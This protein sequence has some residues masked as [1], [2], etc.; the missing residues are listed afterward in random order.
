MQMNTS[1]VDA[2]PLVPP[3][4]IAE[5]GARISAVVDQTPLMKNHNLSQKYNCNIFLKREDMQAVRSFKIRG[6]YN[7]IS[8]LSPSEKASG[9][10]CASAGNHAQGVAF[11]CAHLKI[12]GRIF[13]PNP[14]P[15][16]KISKVKQFGGEWIEVVMHGD[17]YDD[18][19]DKALEDCKL[20]GACFVHPF[21]D[22]SVIA[23][24]G[25]VASEILDQVDVGL[26]YILVAVG[27]GGLI[28]GVGS[29]FKTHSPS[30][31]VISVEAEGAAGMKTS[32]ANKTLTRLETIDTFADG[33]AVKEVGKL[34]FDICRQ[35]VDKSIVVPEGKICST[36]LS[37]YNNEAIVV[38]PAG[39]VSIAALDFIAEEIEGK[40]V[41][42]IVCGGNNDI[43][44]TQE[45]R[46]R[47]MLYEGLKHYF[48]I[49][50]PQRAGA[51]RDF[52]SVLGPDDDIAHFEYTKKTNRENG[53]AMVGIELKSHQDFQ[54]LI[55]RMQAHGIN[56]QHINKNPLLFEMLV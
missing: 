14:T 45:I 39:A 40:N 26:D 54:P 2:A 36:I 50:F 11:A 9:I 1:A 24:Q 53:P 20:T 12:K 49:K 33:I 3:A 4:L 27:G 21:D 56:Y 5:A 35:V 23:G 46:E 29:Y 48:I 55:D 34:T 13:M 25:T 8:S 17:T 43:Q 51:L 47:A 44:R 19:C 10:V 15:S 52:L 18:A 22:L 30:T 6:A 37:L 31:K 42:I 28:S 38:E 7:K 41:A 16:Q 32:L